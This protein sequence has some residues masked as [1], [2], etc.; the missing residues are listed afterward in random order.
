[1]NYEVVIGLETHTEL[2]TVSK[3]FC[4]CDASFGGEPNTHVCPVC[5]GLPGTLP[6]LNRRSLDLSIR[7]A[8]ALQCEVPLRFQFDRKNY[9]YPDMPKNYQISQE[10]L[11]L[12]KDGKLTIVL[13][14][15]S[16]KDIR[17]HNVHLEEDAGKLVHEPGIGGLVDLNR[18]SCSLLEIVSQPDMCSL[19]E[20]EAYMSTMRQLLRYIGASDCKMQEGS[21][22]FEVNISLRPPGQEEL[23]TK[24][25]LKNIGSMKAA[26]RAAAFE[27]ERQG[28]A[29][30]NNEPLVQ[31]TR[32]W[33]D[34]KGITASMRSK[35]GAKDYRYF[36]EPDLVPVVIDPAW[37]QKMKDDLPELPTARRKRFAKEYGLPDYDAGVLTA[38]RETADFYEQAISDKKHAKTI[39]NWMMTYLL[40]MLESEDDRVT[41][42]KAKPEHMAELAELVAA[43]TISGNQAKEVIQAVLDTGEAPGKVVEKRGMKQVTDTGAIE[44]FVDEVVAQFPKEVEQY[45][46]GQTKVIGFFVGQIMKASKG[47][48]NPKLVN[49]LL[50]KKL[51]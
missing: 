6:V 29:L 44:K 51:A 22:R 42:L 27:I 30:N 8:L 2:D 46:A 25:E 15:G 17:I 13:P 10:Y 23:G 21:L 5:L 7:T 31:E 48:A 37:L 38:D 47:Q 35:E 32:L 28:D 43:G 9:Y 16:E 3:V 34:N 11:P 4:R 20:M 49:E 19:E 40:K 36:P 50:R 1:M 45:K 12:G 14:D 33:D 18:A 39:S 24:V 41:D 26:L